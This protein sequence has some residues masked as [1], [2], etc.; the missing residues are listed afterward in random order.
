MFL[1]SWIRLGTT[2]L[3]LGGRRVVP[4]WPMHTILATDLQAQPQLVSGCGCAA[5]QNLLGKVF[6]QAGCLVRTVRGVAA[7]FLSVLGAIVSAAEL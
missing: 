6:Q 4:R 3:A 5:S 7:R 1:E 2:T